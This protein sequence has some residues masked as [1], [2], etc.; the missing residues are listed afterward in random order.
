MPLSTEPVVTGGYGSMVVSTAPE[1]TGVLAPHTGVKI[2][3][4]SPMGVLFRLSVLRLPSPCQK[5]NC[6]T[7]CTVRV[8]VLEIPML[9]RLRRGGTF[10]RPSC[11]TIP[12]GWPSAQLK[13]SPLVPTTVAWSET[14][15]SIAVTRWRPVTVPF[16][17]SGLSR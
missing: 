9:E 16:A 10:N 6:A 12:L 11:M 8:P 5:P 3:V 7:R 15:F 1:T 2:V 17:S 4:P 14:A 13:R